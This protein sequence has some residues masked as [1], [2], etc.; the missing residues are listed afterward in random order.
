MAKVET[1]YIR[2]GRVITR[3][4]VDPPDVLAFDSVNKAKAESLKLQKANG[5]LGAGFV[6]VVRK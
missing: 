6:K 3:I 5:G 1:K 4:D 2:K